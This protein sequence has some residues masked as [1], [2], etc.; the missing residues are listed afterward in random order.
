MKQT[1]N[2]LILGG[3]AVVL[4]VAAILIIVIGQSVPTDDPQP[5]DTTVDT[6]G[7]SNNPS[8]AANS[9][10]E[11]GAH[12]RPLLSFPALRGTNLNLATVRVPTDLTAGPKLIV[13]SYDDDQQSIVDDWF[14]PLLDINAAFPGLSGYYTP[15][16]PKDAADSA[17]FII[18]GFALLASEDERERTIIVFTNVALFNE[19]T[20]VSST[21]TIQ[22]FLLNNAHEIVWR[23]SGAV[24][25]SKLAAL[26]GE[27]ATLDGANPSAP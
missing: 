11:S 4:T 15:L 21:D 6:L 25:D 18:G 1:R 5:I 17:S 26:Q 24:N 22:L 10:D 9:A 20:Q 3:I 2:T 13:V 19:L 16:L 12:T 23:A 7:S 14:E 8:S 27:L